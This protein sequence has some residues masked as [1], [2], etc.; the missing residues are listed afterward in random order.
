MKTLTD[1]VQELLDLIEGTGTEIEIK[2]TERCAYSYITVKDSLADELLKEKDLIRKLIPYNKTCL[3][4]KT[5]GNMRVS[6]IMTIEE[7]EQLRKELMD[8]RV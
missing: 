4:Y 6:T 2:D 1:K 7:A 8:E 5:F 3:V